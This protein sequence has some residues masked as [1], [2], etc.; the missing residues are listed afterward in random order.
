MNIVGKVLIVN[1]HC[2]ASVAC[3]ATPRTRFISTQVVRFKKKKKEE[4]KR[5]IHRAMI[6]LHG[7]SSTHPSSNNSRANS[8]L[9][10]CLIRDLHT[11]SRYFDFGRATASRFI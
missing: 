2:G 9:P 1:G 10:P 6:S 5:W 3:R 4:R 11:L 7:P 8:C